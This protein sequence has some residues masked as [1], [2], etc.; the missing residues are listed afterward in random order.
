MFLNKHL[1]K[2]G[3]SA[4][5]IIIWVV[6]VGAIIIYSPKLYNYYIERETVRIIK[7]NMASVEDEIRSQL[8]E[9]HPILIWNDIDK[10]IKSLKIQNPVTKEIQIKNFFNIPGAVAVYFDGVNTFT[11]DGVGSNG[12]YLNINI[13]VIK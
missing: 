10:V 4:V 6:I 3:I 5:T 9:K 13:T 8:I 1:N 7:S 12:K 11:I 2:K